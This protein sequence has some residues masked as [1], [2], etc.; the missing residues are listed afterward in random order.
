M[1]VVIGLLLVLAVL[2]IWTGIQIVPDGYGRIVERLGRRHRVLMPGINITVPV[3][4][5]I[6]KSGFD[7]LT[8]THMEEEEGKMVSNSVALWNKRGNVSLAEH[9]MDPPKGHF[10]AKDNS[11]I[12]VDSVAYFRIVDPMKAAYDVAAFEPT[13]TSLIETTLRQEVGRQDGDSIITSREIMGEN[14]RSAL[15]EAAG[16]WGVQII[17]VEIED[18]HFNPEVARELSEARERE[19]IRRAELVEKK[20]QAEQQILLADA[21]KKASILEAEGKM[22]ADIKE[23]EGKK[24][25]QILIAEGEFEKDKLEAEGQYLSESRQKEGEAKGFSAIVAALSQNPEA[26]VALQALTAQERVAESLGKSTNALI[27]PSDTAGLFGAA[28]SIIKGYEHMKK[29]E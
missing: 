22:E 1:L 13:F 29:K 23:A 17:R 20:G 11:D 12:W 15:Q 7:Q 27:V 5:K 28:A 10:L 8:V 19:L 4:D 26:I 21:A 18:I 16:A 6:K 24:Q 9:R 14:L 3:I 25:A 2:F